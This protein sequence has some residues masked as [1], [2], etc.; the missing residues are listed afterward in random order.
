[1]S[2]ILSLNIKLYIIRQLAAMKI[3][4]VDFVFSVANLFFP[5]SSSLKRSLIVFLFCMLFK[6]FFFFLLKSCL[7][8]WW[9]PLMYLEAPVSSHSQSDE[10]CVFFQFILHQNDR[11]HDWRLTKIQLQNKILLNDFITEKYLGKSS[12][13]LFGNV[14]NVCVCGLQWHLK[15]GSLNGKCF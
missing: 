1:M 14:V 4:V 3:D 15:R 12:V 7:R 11:N 5:P 9:I 10:L 13:D 2:E 6:F 8:R